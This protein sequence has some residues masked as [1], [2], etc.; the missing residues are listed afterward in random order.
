MLN[1]AELLSKLQPVEKQRLRDLGDILQYALPWAAL[2]FVAL[3]GDAAGAELWLKV[4]LTST[5]LTQL[6]KW[7]FDR[8]PY[9]KRPDGGSGAMPSGHTASAFMG[10]SF[11]H[12]YFSLEMALIAY[13]LAALTGYSRVVAKRHWWR[14][15]IAG[16]LLSIA[17]SYGYLV[18]A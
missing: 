18:A 5:L 16:A 13:A 7:A 6:G 14:D 12:F 2:L 1:S 15:V 11:L 17:I 3:E 4:G 9:G 10:A 8:T